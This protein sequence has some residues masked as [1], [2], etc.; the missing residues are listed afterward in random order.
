MKEHKFYKEL[1]DLGINT[2]ID[3]GASDGI[4]IKQFRKYYPLA[5]IHAFEPQEVFC[6]K[7]KKE[8]SNIEVYKF[9]LYNKTT[10]KLFYIK[11][12]RRASS[13]IEPRKSNNKELQLIDVSMVSTVRFDDLNINI[14][15]PCFVK[16]DVERAEREVIEGFGERLKEVDVLQFE[17]HIQDTFNKVDRNKI[18]SLLLTYGFKRF[19]EHIFEFDKDGNPKTCDIICFKEKTKK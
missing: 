3:I 10:N 17:F 19:K 12:S 1:R 18:M 7:I 8:F 2:F 5:K 9:C 13:L 6:N 16:I 4:I 15:R 14:K 11:K